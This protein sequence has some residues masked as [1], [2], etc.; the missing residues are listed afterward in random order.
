MT[1]ICFYFQV[2]QPLRTKRYRVFDIGSDH[3]YFNDRSSMNTNNREVFSKVSKKCYFPANETILKLLKKY[4][5]FKV[6]YS[7]S[8]V[9]LEQALEFGNEVIDS[10]R[11]LIDTGRVE[12]L[13]ETYYH[14]LSFFYSKV[15]FEKQVN[16]HKGMVKKLFGVETQVFRNTELA[17][18]NDLAA[19]AE[20]NGF[21]GILAE[22]WGS[23]LGWR[24]PN[25]VYRP[26]G[27]EKIKLLLK[28]YK[29]SDDI[30]FRFSDKSWSE[31]PLTSQKYSAWI[32][33]V[34]KNAQ[35]INLFMDYETFGEHQWRSTG[36]F[37]FLESLPVEILKN[38]NI[39]FA[40]PGEV[41][42]RFK[43]V[44]E[45]DV[46]AVLTWADTERD[47]SA[48]TGNEIQQSAIA[49]LYSLERKILATD[50]QKII[51]DW[52][53]LTTSDHFYYMCTKWS[54]D[55]DVHKYF[56][57]HDSPYDAYI[58]FMNILRDLNLRVENY[59]RMA[60]RATGPG[61]EVNMNNARK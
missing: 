15:E 39:Y 40:T 41:I 20:N 23:V 45:I 16:F 13:S 60:R 22:G 56:N 53:M 34:E 54:G 4:K 5:E 48:W 3:E 29:L 12:I 55:G 36:I 2:H 11:R 21:R 10:F 8:G 25:F 32:S 47:L 35:T 44:G 14:S 28:N 51:R 61:G 31:W 6:S 26:K 7:F 19:W 30:A 42:S 37:E 58:N 59:R 18:T 50:D 27:T 38:E 57:P 33:E 46:P 52:R 9:F 17:Y 43:A 1:A 24:S 49:E